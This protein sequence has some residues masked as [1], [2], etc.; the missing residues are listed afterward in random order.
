MMYCL[1]SAAL[2]FL[3][4]V[5]MCGIYRINELEHNANYKK[6]K[7]KQS[8][9]TS[10]SEVVR[11]VPNQEFLQLQATH[12]RSVETILQLEEENELLRRAVRAVL[13]IRMC[14]MY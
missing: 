13:S 10:G 12:E 9:S 3:S 11:F 6:Y 4:Y 2:V 14:T 7:S 1:N 8:L 5:Y